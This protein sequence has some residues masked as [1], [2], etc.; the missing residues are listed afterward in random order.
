MSAD[1]ADLSD[2]SFIVRDVVD[3]R[4]RPADTDAAT[5]EL[6]IS[7]WRGMSSA[8]RARMVRALWSASTRMAVIGIRERHPD[9]SD[10]EVLYRLGVLRMGKDLVKQAVGWDADAHG[11]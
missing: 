5:W 10:L 8:E 3:L 6:M 1:P 7:E 4:A 11:Y 2:L 9:A